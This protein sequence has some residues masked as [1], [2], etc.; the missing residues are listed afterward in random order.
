M[1][2]SSAA[3]A[4]L[5]DRW[6]TAARRSNMGALAHAFLLPVEQFFLASKSRIR[7]VVASEADKATDPSSTDKCSCRARRRRSNCEVRA[8]TACS[9]FSVT[10]VGV[11]FEARVAGNAIA[12]TN[13]N[14]RQNFILESEKR[15][16]GCVRGSWRA[17]VE[18]K[19]GDI[20]SS[21]PDGRCGCPKERIIAQSD[22]RLVSLYCPRPQW[23]LV[24][25][26]ILS[27]RVAT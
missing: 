17:G 2:F 19:E 8:D 26:E 9:I 11:G 13:A 15:T 1:R 24:L 10:S 21:V 7:A 18:S 20:G 25:C 12:N 3:T 5:A 23:Q 6:S 4:F 22:M 27:R 16:E 14:S